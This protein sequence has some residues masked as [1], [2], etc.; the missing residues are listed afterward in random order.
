MLILII[1]CVCG[2]WQGVIIYPWMGLSLLG[3]VNIAAF[4]TICFLALVSHGKG[5]ETPSPMNDTTV[6]T[7]DSA[8]VHGERHLTTV[9]DACDSDADG[10]GRRAAERA[11]PCAH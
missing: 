8:S 9:C 5:I 11:T 1:I 4:T 10:P 7:M 3:L 6:A 2:V